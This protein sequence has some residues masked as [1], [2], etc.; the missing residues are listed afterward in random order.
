[1]VAHEKANGG[2][3]HTELFLLTRQAVGDAT[4]GAANATEPEPPATMVVQRERRRT[5]RV[6]LKIGGRGF[7]LPGL[8]AAQRQVLLKSETTDIC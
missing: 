4:A 5:I 6:P 2:L 3:R 7:L 1:M 8:S